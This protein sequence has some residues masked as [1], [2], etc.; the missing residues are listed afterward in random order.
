VA[1]LSIIKMR[2]KGSRAQVIGEVGYGNAAWLGQHLRELEGD[3]T[4]DCR[5]SA[6]VDPAALMV[7]VEFEEFLRRRGNRLTI[8]GVPNGAE[9]HAA[10]LPHVASRR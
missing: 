5:S 2:T 7:L 10:A 1:A 4:L 3:V 6:F 8:D 9:S